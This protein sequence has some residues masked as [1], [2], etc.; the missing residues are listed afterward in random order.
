MNPEKLA[1]LQA[2]GRTGSKGTPRRVIKKVHR[3]VAQDD[4]KL[5]GALEKLALTNMPYVE[6]VNMFKEEGTI[7]HFRAPKVHSSVTSN[8]YAV[9]GRGEEKEMTELVP[10]ILNQL[11]PDSLASLRR[12]AQSYQESAAAQAGASPEDDD[13]EVPALVES[14]E[15]AT[16]EETA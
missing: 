13:D 4:R 2:Q 8:T 12:L 10:G 7:L 6:E 11:G 14:F 3:A 15:E 9:Y 5:Q 16:I 1:K